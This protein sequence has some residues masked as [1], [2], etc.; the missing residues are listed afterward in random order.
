M[1]E[2]QKTVLPNGLTLFTYVDTTVPTISYQTFI[3]A[4]SRDETKPGAT[5]IAHI[6]ER[7]MFC[8]TDAYPDYSN[9]M[10]HMGA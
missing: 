10:A 8:G 4:G 3:N 6:F 5:G 7:M 2:A 9:A 1:F